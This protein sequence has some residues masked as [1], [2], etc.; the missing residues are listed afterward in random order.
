[1]H[2]EAWAQCWRRAGRTALRNKPWAPN[3]PARQHRLP[4][5]SAPTLIPQEQRPEGPTGDSGLQL[6][7]SSAGLLAYQAHLGRRCPWA[8]FLPCRTVQSGFRPPSPA[9]GV[10]NTR[11]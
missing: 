8:G 4:G 9:T 11:T 2:A 6:P 1:M 3:G 10:K 7:G 5:T